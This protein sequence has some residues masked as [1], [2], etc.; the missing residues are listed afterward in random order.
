[1]AKTD[2]FFI[3]QSVTIAA[4]TFNQDT[5]DLG[6]YVDALGKAVL[7]IKNLAVTFSDTSGRTPDMTG[8]KNASCDFQL[9]TQTQADMVI[10]GDNRSV[11]ASGRI[12]AESSQGAGVPSSVSHDLDVTPQHWDNGYLIGVDTLYLSGRATG[13]GWS[14][15]IVVSIVMECVSES[16]TQAAAMALA[17]SQS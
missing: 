3:R 17:L 8:S 2:S 13:T 10:P 7:R 4:G 14:E 6:A 9:T 11:V 5:I 16:L 15:S 1:M 12:V